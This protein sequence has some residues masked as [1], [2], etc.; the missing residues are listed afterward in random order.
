M[1]RRPSSTRLIRQA[2]VRSRIKQRILFSLLDLKEGSITDLAREARTTPQYVRGAI[3]GAPLAF[4]RATALR[5][6]RLVVVHE[7]VL[8]EVVRLTPQGRRVAEAWR[9]EASRAT[10]GLPRG[11][12]A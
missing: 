4:R 5:K 11:P 7:S 8:G 6:L 3:F 12:H 9:R 10:L 1:N 2:L